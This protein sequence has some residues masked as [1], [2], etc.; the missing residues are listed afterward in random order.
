MNKDAPFSIYPQPSVSYLVAALLDRWI[1]R[2]LVTG[3]A[4]RES[5]V[6][7]LAVRADVTQVAF[8][9]IA[10][11]GVTTYAIDLAMLAGRF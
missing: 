2:V 4:F 6:Q 9:D 11:L 10:V 3:Q 1:M 8:R 5:F 7:F